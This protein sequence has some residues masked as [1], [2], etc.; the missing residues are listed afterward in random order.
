VLPL[1]HAAAVFSAF[2]CVYAGGTLVLL[3]GFDPGQ[4]IDV[5]AAERIGIAVVVPTMLQRV[6][7]ELRGTRRRHYE[8]LRL[9]QYGASPISDATLREALEVFGCP[10]L[11]AYGMT[12]ATVA[13]TFLSPH[14]HLLGVSGQPELLRSAG[15][16]AA[17]TRIAVVDGAGQPTPPGVT[18]E[19]VAAG[20]QLMRCYWQRPDD[21]GAAL[22]DGWLH[23]GDLGTM[24]E[25]GY[26]YVRDRLKDLIVSGGENISAR[27]V[28]EVLLQHPAVGEAAVIGVPDDVW[29]ETVKAV[30][31]LRPELGSD[32]SDIVEYCRGRLPGFARPRSVDVVSSLPRTASGKILKHQIR[33]PY[34]RDHERMVAGP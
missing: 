1:F 26:L 33:A 4:L 21:S 13:L 27:E 15:R 6:L 12:E 3:E 7:A 25:R 11:Q 16:P 23:T 30:V 14:D 28:E 2:S 18:G 19:I 9:V 22:R 17:G 10:F 32:P 29:G 8:S 31:V 20:P 5:L 24:D 34:W